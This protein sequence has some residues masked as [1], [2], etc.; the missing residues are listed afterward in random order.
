M[1]IKKSNC[2]ETTQ[3]IIKGLKSKGMDFPTMVT[4]EYQVNGV[5]YEVVESLKLKSEVIKFVFL[6]IGQNRVPTMGDTRV[7]SAAQVNYNP[8]NPKEAFIT[9]NTGKANV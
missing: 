2:T 7:G 8:M 6:P 5:N 1:K 4:V 9:K 3:G